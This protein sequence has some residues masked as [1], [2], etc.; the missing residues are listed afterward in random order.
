MCIQITMCYKWN[1]HHF[2]VDWIIHMVHEGHLA[3]ETFHM[4]KHDPSYLEV[5]TRLHLLHQVTSTIVSIYKH[6]E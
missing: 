3:F 1:H 4:I 6:L 2:I 5:L